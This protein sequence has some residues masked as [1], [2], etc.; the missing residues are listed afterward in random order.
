M[1]AKK[2]FKKS[3]K[4]KTPMTA[5]DEVPQITKRS[6]VR[7]SA[8]CHGASGTVGAKDGSGSGGSKQ[9]H[10]P[11]NC[12][13]DVLEPRNVSP[14]MSGNDSTVVGC[15][16]IMAPYL[17]DCSQHLIRSP[18]SRN[19]NRQQP[20]SRDMQAIN[21]RYRRSDKDDHINPIY[22]EKRPLAAIIEIANLSTDPMSSSTETG[23]MDGYLLGD[24][25]YPFRH[26]LLTPYLNTRSP[27][28]ER[29][30]FAQTFFS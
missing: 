28:Q 18:G 23:V 10:S 24:S 6:I 29:D 20:I 9:Q 4:C 2:K 8:C 16:T 13:V 25:G 11:E 19:K 30:V 7:G 5:S 22:D 21:Y 1:P 27:A 17:L 26:Y 3:D 15:V 12:S 14:M